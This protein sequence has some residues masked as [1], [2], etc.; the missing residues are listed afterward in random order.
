MIQIPIQTKIIHSHYPLQTLVYLIQF[1]RKQ[2]SPRNYDPP[3]LPPQYAT[4]N[5]LQ[6][7]L[8]RGSS[9]TNATD[10]SQNP[11]AVQFQTTTPTRQPILQ[12]LP[13]TP[14]QNT[15]T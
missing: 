1:K 2:P 12:T 8:Q 10:T 15:Q 3:P 11:P 13:H 4:H 5:T 7:S 6:N 9:N 14:A